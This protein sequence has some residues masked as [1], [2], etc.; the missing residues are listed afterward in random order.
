MGGG[1]SAA[2]YFPPA[3]APL[4]SIINITVVTVRQQRCGFIDGAIRLCIG[5]ITVFTERLNSNIRSSSLEACFSVGQEEH[6]LSWLKRW[7]RREL[8]Y[9]RERRVENIMR[10]QKE[11]FKFQ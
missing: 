6:A 8:L 5:K 9:W 2:E 4:T 11:I 7:A 10:L 3:A 1:G